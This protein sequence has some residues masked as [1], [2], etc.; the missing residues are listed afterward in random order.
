[1]G[2]FHSKQR[3][4]LKTATNEMETTI[5]LHYQSFKPVRLSSSEVA[6]RA[7]FDAEVDS[8]IAD[9]NMA[10]AARMP[11][12]LQPLVAA[13]QYAANA[14]TSQ[15]QDEAVTPDEL[16]EELT[17]LHAALQPP[18]GFSSWQAA[19]ADAFGGWDFGS[20]LLDS[21]YTEVFVAP[22]IAVR[23][24]T[25]GQFD[26]AALVQEQLQQEVQ[27]QQQ[28]YLQLLQYPQLQQ[29]PAGLA[30]NTQQ[31]V[32]LQQQQL[33]LQQQQQQQQQFLQ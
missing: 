22:E 26:V 6:K 3:N 29:V 4:Q 10:D 14:A 5:K 23:L 8:S 12:A 31:Q 19:V 7:R 11:E 21:S 2:Y 9:A 18:S 27:Q 13:N 33:L 15:Q 28:Q 16:Q 24:P 25:T 20:N 30:L 1:M 17:R 32:V